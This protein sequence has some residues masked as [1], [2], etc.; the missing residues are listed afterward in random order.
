MAKK[1]RSTTQK[2]TVSARARTRLQMSGEARLMTRRAK[3]AKQMR[4]ELGYGDY[5]AP[6]FSSAELASVETRSSRPVGKVNK[7]VRQPK[8]VQLFTKQ[9][10]SICQTRAIR[11]EVIFATGYGGKRGPQAP[12]KPK[13][14]VRCS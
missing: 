9:P 5:Q 1:K 13:S 10:P 7:Q 4:L 8:Q 2:R 14:K 3:P 11:K 12:H 6:L